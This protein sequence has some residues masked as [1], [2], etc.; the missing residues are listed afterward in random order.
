[1]KRFV[2][3][4][5]DTIDF[6]D[7]RPT[8]SFY[9]SDGDNVQWMF[10]DYV[11]N[12]YYWGAEVNGTFPM[13]WGMP[14]GDLQQIGIDIYNKLANTQ[15]EQTSVIFMP[16][17]SFPDEFGI[18]YDD[19]RREELL[20]QH[21]HRIE[22]YMQENGVG[23]I[24]FLCNDYDSEEA[25]EAYRIFAREI[26]SLVGMLCIDYA[27]YEEGD[28]IVFWFPNQ[29]G[30]E[31]PV[32]TAKYAIWANL[33]QERAGTPA[34]IARLINKDSAA[35]IEHNETYNNWVTVHAWS[36]FKANDTD[37]ETAGNGQFMAHGTEGG[38]M[39]VK[40]TIDRLDDDHVRT[41]TPEEMV[42]RLRMDHQPEQTKKVIKSL[43]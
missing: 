40:W 26:P 31:I 23:L 7:D 18:A 39:P 17:Y 42:W 11:Q 19:E 13:G 33:N 5:P 20:I 32:V 41:V 15:P 29:D 6:K 43:K 35:A 36:G 10:G 28:G 12:P 8:V 1:L 22:H 9:M 27:P 34:K 25:M 24:S 2:Q 16:G 38:I 30:V 14:L 4:D 37:D 21:A 3:I